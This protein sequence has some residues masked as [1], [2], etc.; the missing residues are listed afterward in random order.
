MHSIGY[1]NPQTRLK[2]DSQRQQY[3][4]VVSTI[5]NSCINNREQ[6]YQQQ[7]MVI[8]TIENGYINNIEWLYQ[9]YRIV[10]STKVKNKFSNE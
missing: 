6:L 2:L 10:I 1:M 5:E 9:Q 8:S 7:R 3:R 4:I